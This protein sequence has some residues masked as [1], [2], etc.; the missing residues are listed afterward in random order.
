MSNDEVGVKSD[1]HR[2]RYRSVVREETAA[3]TKERVVEAALEEFL[4]VGY[5]SATIDRI[6]ARANVSRPTVFAVGSKAVLLKLARDRAIAGDFRDESMT[7]R[8]SFRDLAAA[9][10]AEEVLRRFAKISADIFGRYA[11]LDDVLRQGA[12]V[13]K[14]VAQLYIAAEQE[15]LAGAENVVRIVASKGDL[16]DGLTAKRAAEVLWLLMAPEHHRRLVVD[17]EWSADEF[18]HWYAESMVR[19]LLPTPAVP[20]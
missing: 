8:P 7:G 15:R 16:R 20:K 4:A 6:A 9:P 13:D 3:R 10:D 14:D 18:E 19:L 12:A 2:R 17:R 5:A 11:G 1:G